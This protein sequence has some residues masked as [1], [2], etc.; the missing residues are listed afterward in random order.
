MAFKDILSIVI[1]LFTLFSLRQI[2]FQI[3]TI[4]ERMGNFEEKLGNVQEGLGYKISATEATLSK[5]ITDSF[6]KSHYFDRA[7][8]T[9]LKNSTM[10]FSTRCDYVSTIHTVYFDG[11]V[12]SLFTPHMTCGI[13]DISIL[14]PIYDLGL[15][16]SK[17]LLSKSAID[18]TLGASPHLGDSVISYGFG[19]TVS[20][21]K[22][23]VSHF[24]AN[25]CNTPATHFNGTT[26]VCDG[27]MLMQGEQ[28]AGM[29]GSAVINGCGYLGIAHAMVFT[30]ERSSNFA[31][32]INFTVIRNFITDNKHN[33][34]KWN[35]SMGI[36]I[37]A[38]PHAPGV[39][40]NEEV[41]VNPMQCHV[42]S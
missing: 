33:L 34:L 24:S 30:R 2:M 40:C 3:I 36:E 18:I 5:L 26:R 12:V 1:S 42:S 27:E 10:K 39:N 38:L 8:V 13:E 21:W 41:N 7:R 25:V 29:S 22:G 15:L 11:C 19:E 31:A 37:V 35:S 17:H 20:I 32:V 4:E 14:H 6:T 9:S 28:H 16:P 23:Y